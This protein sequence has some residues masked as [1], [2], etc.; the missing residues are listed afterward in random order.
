[1]ILSFLRK[2][3]NILELYFDLRETPVTPSVFSRNL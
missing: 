3:V 1:M 2:A